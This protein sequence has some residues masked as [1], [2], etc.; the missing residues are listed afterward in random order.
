M[1]SYGFSV[2]FFYGKTCNLWGSSAKRVIFFLDTFTK[3]TKTLFLKKNHFHESLPL[4]NTFH[5]KRILKNCD[6]RHYNC[7]TASNC[8]FYGF[9]D[10]I[11]LW[12]LKFK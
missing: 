2:D 9:I 3:I 5:S 4:D 12:F 8:T 6:F 1:Q 10:S 7:A 11:V